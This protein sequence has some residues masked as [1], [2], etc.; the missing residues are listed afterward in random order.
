MTLPW[1]DSPYGFA[2]VPGNLEC[3]FQIARA[4]GMSWM[5]PIHDFINIDTNSSNHSDPSTWNWTTMD[6]DVAF[7]YEYQ[8]NYTFV[9]S[10]CGTWG[11][12]VFPGACTSLQIDPVYALFAVQ[13]VLNRYN[14]GQQPGVIA[15]VEL[16]NEGYDDSGLGSPC[17]SF[18]ALVPVM[19]SCYPWI[20]ANYPDVLVGMG[21]HNNRLFA[22]ITPVHETLYTG[23]Y[24]SALGLFDYSNYHWYGQVNPGTGYTGPDG[25][26]DPGKATFNAEWQAIHSV[27]VAYGNAK[28]PI[29]CT[30]TGMSVPGGSGNNTEDQKGLYMTSVLTDGLLSHGILTHIGIWTIQPT[31]GYGITQGCS[32]VT[33]RPA[34]YAIQKFI[35]KHPQWNLEF[36]DGT[37]TAFAR[38]GRCTAFARDGH[39]TTLV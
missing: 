17:N 10:N 5:R 14:G 33:Y 7:A 3:V 21:A 11:Q 4:A 27:D 8:L 34:F 16:G 38:D 32:S 20:K 36:Q 30:E 19:Q 23:R 9:L 1:P 29:Y 12:K 35:S 6:S 13:T 15:R 28:Q 31:D 37:I 26:Q 22:D 2:G 25:P 24:G 39:I 18:E